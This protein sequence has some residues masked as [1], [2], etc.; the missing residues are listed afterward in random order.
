MASIDQVRVWL[1]EALAA[2]HALMTGRSVVR[3]SSEDGSVEFTAANSD[4]LDAWIGT[5][6][7]QVAA[8]SVSTRS[9]ARPVYFGF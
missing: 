7:A 8:G 6:Q 3:V 5:L 2:K 4:R 9:G 1:D